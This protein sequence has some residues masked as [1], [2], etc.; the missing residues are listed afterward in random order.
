[1]N[2]SEWVL[3]LGLT[4]VAVT[5][6]DQSPPP[7]AAEKNLEE[8]LA[9]MSAETM[10]ETNE[11]G[12]IAYLTEAMPED[13][14]LEGFQE[15]YRG[16]DSVISAQLSY[17]GD[18]GGS[19]GYS[20]IVLDAAQAG[21]ED[22]GSSWSEMIDGNRVGMETVIKSQQMIRDGYLAGSTAS[23]E[24]MKRIPEEITLPNGAKAM[25]FTESNDW[26]LLSLLNERHALR[27]DISD[28]SWD[29]FST[30]QAKQK[31]AGLVSKVKLDRL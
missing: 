2:R 4:L 31:V 30:E 24:Q 12:A 5:G 26:V 6:C 25:L 17:A 23:A 14:S 18:E 29:G 1:M 27:I 13:K 28:A 19:I 22:E 10:D 11:C 20:L 16:C 15:I 3:L 9:A 7:V 8:A 21:L